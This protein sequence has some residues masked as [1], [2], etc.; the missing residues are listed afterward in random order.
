MVAQDH[1][2]HF[3]RGEHAGGH[4]II[5]HGTRLA[6]QALHHAQAFHGRHMGQHHTGGAQQI[7]DGV[8]FGQGSLQGIVH[9]DPAAAVGPDTGFGQPQA[10]RGRATAHGHQHH[11]GFHRHF[12]LLGGRGL[13]HPHVLE[14]TTQLAGDATLLHLALQQGAD[15]GIHGRHGQQTVLSFHHGHLRAEGTVDE[16]HLAADDTT[17][18]DDQ[19]LRHTVQLQGIIAAQDV[20]R[21]APPPG[22]RSPG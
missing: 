20:D 6:A 4:G 5:A 8:H 16:R 10:F 1:A 15:I 7:T 19:A 18:H 2:A 17:A 14:G 9:H 11:V 3:G 13:V 21:A 12:L 22:S